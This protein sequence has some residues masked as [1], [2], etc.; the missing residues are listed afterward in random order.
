MTGELNSNLGVVRDLTFT[1]RSN[2]NIICRY[3]F[4][5]HSKYFLCNNNNGN[6]Y[7]DNSL[8]ITSKY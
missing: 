6:V 3:K 8:N 7:T 5:F 2:V 1:I 4:V